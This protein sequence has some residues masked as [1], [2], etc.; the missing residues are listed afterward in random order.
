[1]KADLADVRERY[2]K[3]TSAA[4]KRFVLLLVAVAA[5]QRFWL[6]LEPITAQEAV[7]YM[8]FATRSVG[9]CISDYSL[10]VNHVFH[11]LLT[12]LSTAVAGANLIGLRLPAIL[13]SLLALPLYYLFV[14]SMFNRY[15]ALMAL[16][17]AAV[18]PSLAELGALAHGYSLTWLCLMLAL[19]FGRHFVRTNNLVSAIAIGLACAFGMWAVPSSLTAVLLVYIWAL[20]S[21]LGKYDRSLGE[22]LGMLGLSAGVFLAA[23]LLL[24][25]PVVMTH[26]V[27]QLFHHVT[28]EDRNWRAF[29]L[30][31]PDQVLDF[32]VW[33]VDP[34]RWWVAILGFIGLVQA[35]YISAKYRALIIALLL[36]AVPVVLLKAD[37]GSPWDWAYTLFIFHLGGAIGLFYL[38]KFLQDHVFPKLG[39]R[40]R[41]G[42]AS[43]VLVVGFGVPGMRVVIER[44]DHLQEARP[45]AEL[46]AA[47][48]K[49]GD[50]LCADGLWEAPVG[51][52]LL[53]AGVA[54]GPLRGS[55]HPGSMLYLVA[56]SPNGLEPAALMLRCDLHAEE[57]VAPVVVKDWPR[58]EIFAARKR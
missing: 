26:G 27:D 10:P 41:T 15:I 24:Y 1:L 53:G 11:T 21:L 6:A 2:V 5:V 39:K 9:Q 19:V 22:R 47:A 38:L 51:F 43:A 30:N 31:Y 13:A 56:S 14:R 23:A 33:V 37:T 25:L 20:F 50:K 48:L 28:E 12:K 3:R 49:P 34:T 54:P 36:G 55:P 40:T 46:L 18:Y 16:A 42:W 52:S 58:M 32:W 8:S 17:M 7:A 45:S 57:F 4:H 35:A 44:V 29:A